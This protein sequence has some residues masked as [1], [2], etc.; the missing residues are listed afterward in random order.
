MS[1]TNRRVFM[2]QAVVATG[3]TLAVGTSQAK[4]KIDETNAEAASVGY[5]LDATKVDAKRFPKYKAGEK[6]V[7]CMA[8]LSKPTDAWGECSLFDN[9]FV[10]A[11]GWCSSYMKG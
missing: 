1:K 9:K 8:W 5:K 2:M 7:N 11:P 4:T 6:C 3:A 10:A